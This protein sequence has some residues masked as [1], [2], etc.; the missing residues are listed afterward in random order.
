MKPVVVG[1]GTDDG[2][3]EGGVVGP[4]EAVDRA[5]GTDGFDDEAWDGCKRTVDDGDE[6][7]DDGLPAEESGAVV[8]CTGDGF[9]EGTGAAVPDNS[10]DGTLG[11]TD[12]AAVA[13][14]SRNALETRSGRKTYLMTR[15]LTAHPMQINAT[16]RTN[17]FRTGASTRALGFSPCTPPPP[18]IAA[19][20]GVGLGVDDAVSTFVSVLFASINVA[21]YRIA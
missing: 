11:L 9:G 2:L 13:G 14:I 3:L 4:V 20:V 6:P 21:S 16:I 18:S 10:D 19:V 7:D 8:T 17:R 5:I 1:V 12:G 15:R